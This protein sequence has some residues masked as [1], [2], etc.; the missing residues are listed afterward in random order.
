MSCSP[1]SWTRFLS[2]SI[3]KQL[4]QLICKNRS[5]ATSQN[6]SMRTSNLRS[7]SKKIF[8][9]WSRLAVWSIKP[10]RRWNRRA[11]PSPTASRKKSK[12]W[13][14]SSNWQLLLIARPYA[15]A[16]SHQVATTSRLGRTHPFSSYL[17]CND[18]SAKALCNRFS[19]F[20]RLTIYTSSP[21]SV[22]PGL[23]TKEGL[24]LAPTTC[25]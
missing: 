10:R 2:S 9:T 21:S 25:M 22:W 24:L 4:N 3:A 11:T 8:S 23:T 20:I 18:S 14:I 17:T 13:T 6:Q 1:L 19:R 12:K 16:S 5:T 15:H 7:R